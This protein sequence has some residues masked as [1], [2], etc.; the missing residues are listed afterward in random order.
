VTIEI[1]LDEKVIKERVKQLA[2]EI[3]NYYRGKTETLHAICVLK[4]SIHFFSE[5]EWESLKE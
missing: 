5:R 2:R 3:E 1:L 4:G